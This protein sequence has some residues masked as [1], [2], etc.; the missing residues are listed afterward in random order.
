MILLILIALLVLN[1]YSKKSGPVFV[2]SLLAM[3]IVMTFTTGNADEEIYVSRYTDPD[4]WKGNTEPLFFALIKLCRLVGLSF[5][6]YKGILAIVYL[7]LIGTTVWKLAKYPNVVLCL[8]FVY[9]FVMNVSQL[10]FGISSAVLVFSCRFLVHDSSNRTGK[11]EHDV[12]VNDL[13][14]SLCVV[15]ASSLHSAALFWLLLLIAKKNTFKVT[16]LWAIL[17]NAFVVLVFNPSSANW[18]LQ[19][20]GAYNRMSAYFTEGYQVS[21]HR[22]IWGP[23]LTALLIFLIIEL[24]CEIVKHNSKIFSGVSDVIELEKYNII[25][26]TVISF[27][28]RFTSEMYRPQEALLPVAYIILTNT[29]DK[30]HSETMAEKSIVSVVQIG[31]LGLVLLCCYRRSVAYGNVDTL[32]LPILRHNLL[33]S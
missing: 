6:Q 1:L 12:T 19:K 25:L 18:I 33:I 10:R 13:L 27:I 31:I 32:W 14:F 3:W 20:T 21:D 5:T 2:L 15:I 9:P 26:I 29:F 7:L 4:L 23:L 24:L 28:Y 22:H 30:K 17:I 8:F 16:A 11:G